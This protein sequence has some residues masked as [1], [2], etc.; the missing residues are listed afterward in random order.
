MLNFDVISE[1]RRESLNEL[2]NSS[3]EKEVQGDVKMKKRKTL[4][5]SGDIQ[6]LP[7]EVND[8][9]LN[10]NISNPKLSIETHP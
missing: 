3:I 7:W 5:G 1:T 2:K 10:S 8:S 6:L 9:L 4:W